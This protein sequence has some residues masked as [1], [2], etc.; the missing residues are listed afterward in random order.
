MFIRSLL[1]TLWW[2]VVSG[3]SQ[4]KVVEVMFQFHHCICIISVILCLI[5]SVL[6]DNKQLGVFAM[7]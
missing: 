5:H 3:H 2:L 4:V 7:A 1:S 6:P